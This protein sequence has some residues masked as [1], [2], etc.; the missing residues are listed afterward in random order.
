M[1]P[2]HGTLTSTSTPSQNEPGSN[3]N[4]E[5]LPKS[6]ELQGEQ[7]AYSKSWKQGVKKKKR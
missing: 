4:E 1:W 6:L 7:S 2:F 5:V 3:D